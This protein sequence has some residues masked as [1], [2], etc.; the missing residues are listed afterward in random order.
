[1][2]SW[3]SRLA[4]YTATNGHLHLFHQLS[5]LSPIDYFAAMATQLC[6]CCW[7]LSSSLLAGLSAADWFLRR[8]GYV[9]SSPLIGVIVFTTTKIFVSFDG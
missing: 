9:T 3:P 4:N 2:V 5:H 6:R 8:H 7:V 1:L